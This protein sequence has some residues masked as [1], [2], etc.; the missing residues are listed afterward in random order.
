MDEQM[1][2]PLLRDADKGKEQLINEL[3]D[4]DRQISGLMHHITEETDYGAGFFNP[5]LKK[6]YEVKNCTTEDCVCYGKGIIRCWQVTGTFCGGEV[7]G[8]FAQKYVKCTECNVFK[9]ATPDPISRIGEQFNNMMYIAELKNHEI[10][11]ANKE[12]TATQSQLLQQEKM[13]SIGQLAAGVAHEINNPMGFISSNLGTLG[14]YTNR[15][16]EFIKSQTG[17]IE[18]LQSTE[19]SDRLK[20]TRRKLKLDYIFEDIEELIKESVDGAERV[21]KIV[22]NLKTF[23]RVDGAEHRHANINECIESTLNIVRNELKYKAVVEKEY[24]EIPLT[25]CYPQQLNQVFVNLLVNAA[26]AIE[27]QGIIKIRTWN[28]DAFI[29]VSI[30][31]TGQGIPEEKL[32]RIFEP[33]FTTKDV[34]EGTGLGLSITYDIVK[35]H[36]GEITVESEVGKGSTFTVKIPVVE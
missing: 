22:Q 28:G 14:K 16:T 30:S 11:K 34:G 21:K 4:L 25:K 19:A 1:S 9:E 13:A 15:L 7:Q 29:C 18:S 32:N 27:K 3:N 26:Q 17:V 20:D 24:G 35:K 8:A 6:C 5:N 31:D 36:K 2:A 12:I 23:S 10:E 33:F